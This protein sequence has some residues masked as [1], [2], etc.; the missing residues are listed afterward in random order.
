[1]NE[2]A[3]VGVVG[4]AGVTGG[5]LLRLLD[6]H[7]GVE[8]AALAGRSSAGQLV[9]EVHP[10]LKAS[11]SGPL[12]IG[13]IEDLGAVD[14]AFL[15]LPRGES[16]TAAPPLLER[17]IRVIDLS[18]DFRLAAEEYPP[19]YGFEHPAPAWLDKAVYG[20]PERFREAVAGADLVANPGCFPTP[21][22][23]GL[24]PLL[25]AGLLEP[26]AIAIDGKT[27]LSGAGSAASDATSFAATEES[28]RPYRFPVHQH[29]PEI[30]RAL[31]ATTS[32]ETT[33]TFVPHLVPAVR[34]VLV[35]C[36]ARAGV[37]STTA[38]LTDRL[39]DAYRGEPFVRV[40]EAGAM[41]DTKRVRGSNVAE[42]HAVVDQRTGT[43]IVVGA[44][45][46]LVKGAA[47]QAI[48]NLN[49]MLGLEET[50]AL[51]TIGMVP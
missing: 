40:L 8:V 36:Y 50:T 24:A 27:G 43:A 49:R 46:N 35:T 26:A 25:E 29:T 34:G 51:P 4:V 30:E 47:G 2:P 6:A 37:G 38:A 18:G 14:V 31:S 3:R 32:I 7:P 23:L 48:Q 10:H 44:I 41:A 42:L 17:G 33:V 45:D 22:V 5:E 21:A 16:A 20:L 9:A 39:A 11:R 15:A 12:T 13:R 19:W 1:M 28:V